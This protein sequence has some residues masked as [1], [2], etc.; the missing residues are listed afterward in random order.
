[1]PGQIGGVQGTPRIRPEDQEHA[2]RV[3][4]RTAT[5]K[6][7]AQ[8]QPASSGGGD[9][10]VKVMIELLKAVK[11]DDSNE[12]KSSKDN[13]KAKSF[14]GKDLNWS[15]FKT[16]FRDES[17]E[18]NW[19]TT[20]DHPH[21]PLD[22]NPDTTFNDNVHRRIF[23][24]LRNLTTDGPGSSCVASA[25]EHDGWSAWR[26][27]CVRCDNRNE[28]KKQFYKRKAATLRHTQG[29]NIAMHL[30]KFHSIFEKLREGFYIPD[31]AEKI[32]WLLDSVHEST[33]D[34]VKS[35]ATA[36]KL[37]GT[38]TFKFLEDMCIST[39]FAKHPQ[40]HIQDAISTGEVRQ[41]NT[42]DKCACC[43][44]TGHTVGVCRKK[45]C[46]QRNKG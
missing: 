36:Q 46:D 8:Q 4:A 7:R 43:N 12:E 10:G 24:R 27:L 22:G 42:N 41:N 6:A 2:Q 31:E 23:T 13:V 19:L 26:N 37:M 35:L 33:C 34:T 1:L 3:A 11:G 18:K 9:D 29:A 17:S 28:S 39:C 44:K 38:L 30:D 14:N 25:P 32:E 20:L 21:E 40:F 15:S 16:S 5:K 45:K